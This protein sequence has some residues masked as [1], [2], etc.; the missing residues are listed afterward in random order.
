MNQ[1][2]RDSLRDAAIEV[3]AE[4]GGR[5]LTHRA[6]DAAAGVPPGTTKNYFPTR[7]ALLRAVAERCV[8]LYHQVPTPPPTDRE[9]LA[10]MLR[11]L[12]ENVAGPGRS[13]LLAISELQ[14]EAARKPWLGAILDRVTAADFADF[15]H[16]QR[17]AG[18]PVTPHRA[19]I[20]TLAL[21]AALSHLLAGG[22]D[23]LAAT[24][25]DDLDEFVHRLLETIYGPPAPGQN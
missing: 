20:L 13:R 4:A 2:R 5:G 11:A 24:G 23:T 21:H 3:L 12:L 9:S 6:V 19:A 17:A 18:L 15:E 22:P 25:L 1:E 16:A 10:A 14:S 7:D 8:E